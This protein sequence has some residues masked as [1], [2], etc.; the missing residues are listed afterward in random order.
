MPGIPADPTGEA[1]SNGSGVTPDEANT[2]VHIHRG[3]LG[4]TNASGGA[5]DLDSTVHRWQNP[6]LKVD[7]TVQ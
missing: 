7:V 3:N 4:D 5:S 6:V 1:G 2:T